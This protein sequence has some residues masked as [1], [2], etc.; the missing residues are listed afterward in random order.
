VLRRAWKFDG[1]RQ[2]PDPEEVRA[3]LPL[4]GWSRVSWR[5]P[6]LTLQPGMEI[7]FGGIGKEYAADRAAVL[8]I[9]HGIRHGFVNLA[10]DVR[11]IG[12]QADGTPWRIGIQHPR[13]ANAVVGTVELIEGSVATSGDYARYFEAGGRRHCHLLDARTGRPVAHWQS[14]SV[15]APLATLAGSYATIA[16]LVGA[17]AER[18]LAQQGVDSLLI[19]A[20]GARVCRGPSF[21]S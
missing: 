18:F 16:M 10:G 3:L 5:R 8:C 15:V 12:P 4:V 2:V 17:D 1:G 14:A 9:D 21:R 7:D 11:V 6:L 13:Q 20:D 19:A